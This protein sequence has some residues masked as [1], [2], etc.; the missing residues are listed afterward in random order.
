MRRFHTSKWNKTIISDHLIIDTICLIFVTNHP[1]TILR[2]INEKV[3]KH[4]I[5][6]ALLKKSKVDGVFSGPRLFPT[7]THPSSMEIFLELYI[8]SCWQTTNQPKVM[9][10]NLT[11]SMEVV[12]GFMILQM[13]VSS[14]FQFSGHDSITFPIETHFSAL[15]NFQ[16]TRYWF[17]K[18]NNSLVVR[19]LSWVD[20]GWV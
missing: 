2:E 18:I 13:I 16:T 17:L 6:N 10:E 1:C 19:L 5:Y 7:K 3:T 15:C 12:R 14:L 8:K 11:P 20:S 4:P 9:D